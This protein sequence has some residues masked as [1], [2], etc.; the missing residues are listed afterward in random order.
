MP[1]PDPVAGGGRHSALQKDTVSYNANAF[2]V[3]ADAD[4]EGLLKKMPGIT[5]N[6]GAVEAQGETIQKVFVDGKEFFGEDVTSAIKS[7]SRPKRSNGSR[8]TTSYTTRP[9][10]VWT[11]AK[12]IRRST[13]S[14]AKICVVAYSVRHM[15]VTV[16]TPTRKPKPKQVYGR[17]Q[18][19]FFQRLQPSVAD[20]SF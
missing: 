3:T 15:P 5:V 18:R 2:K 1:P 7:P 4:V 13:S 11:T 17:R 10:W 14:H 6:N 16:T 8:F 19:Q 20:R 12:A 9:S